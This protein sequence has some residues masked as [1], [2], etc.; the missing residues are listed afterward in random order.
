MAD[1]RFENFEIWQLGA[2]VA[3][4]LCEVAD[5]LS[6]LHLYAFADQLRSAALSITNNIA[7][8]SGSD[9]KAEFRN[10]LNYS[11]RS[12]YECASMVFFF[13]RKGLLTNPQKED[14]IPRLKTLSVK[15]LNFRNSL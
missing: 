1:F 14:F 4:K 11:R 9:S 8:G 5:G 6:A 3:D 7:E 2:D 13:H 12:V 15:I 10:F